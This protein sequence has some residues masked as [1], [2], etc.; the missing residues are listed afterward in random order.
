MYHCG[1]D[2]DTKFW[3]LKDGRKFC[4]NHGDVEE[5][6]D[7]DFKKYRKRIKKHYKEL[8]EI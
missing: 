1:W 4:T 7:K 2:M 3:V 6:T 8:K 5:F